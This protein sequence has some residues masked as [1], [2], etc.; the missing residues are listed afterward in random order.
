MSGVYSP[1]LMTGLLK[2]AENEFAVESNLDQNI[3]DYLKKQQRRVLRNNMVGASLVGAGLGAAIGGGTGRRLAAEF[4]N[5][6][7]Q[8]S[9]P[10]AVGI[11]AAS[12]AGLGLAGSLGGLVSATA[13]ENA[14]MKKQYNE[15]MNSINKTAAE[16]MQIVLLGIQD[17]FGQD[18]EMAFVNNLTKTARLTEEEQ[19]LLEQFRSEA[20]QQLT[21]LQRRYFNEYKAQQKVWEKKKKKKDILKGL[22]LGGAAGATGGTVLGLTSKNKDPVP[23]AIGLGLAGAAGGTLGGYLANKHSKEKIKQELDE[24]SYIKALQGGTPFEPAFDKALLTLPSEYNF[25][26]EKTGAYKKA[27]NK[28]FR[29]LS[30][31]KKSNKQ[32][33]DGLLKRIL[34]LLNGRKVGK[35][36]MEKTSS[37]INSAQHFIKSA[38]E[39]DEKKKKKISPWAVGL[40]AAATAGAGYGI[41]K[42]HTTQQFKQQQEQARLQDPSLPQL[43]NPTTPPE[44]SQ[45]SR[46]QLDVWQNILHPGM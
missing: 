7:V 23:K 34:E 4:Q 40:L 41:G 35:K 11:G 27:T 10:K 22:G 16:K 26:E 37:L 6:G 38:A 8:K 36:P 42:H 20:Y 44:L 14:R 1:E 33:K 31:N 30:E 12:G 2:M 28:F 46:K 43:R 39:E 32:G 21:P 17:G 19:R 3:E 45:Q 9:I 15:Y 18:S 29:T 13:V 25:W 24:I 5:F